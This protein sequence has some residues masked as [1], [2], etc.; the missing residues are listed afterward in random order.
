MLRAT[1]IVLLIAFSP[2][3]ARAEARDVM[4]RFQVS[5]HQP[6]DRGPEFCL[7][8]CAYFAQAELDRRWKP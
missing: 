8:Q 4:E 6:A 3:L 1:V 7:F 5:A 2:P